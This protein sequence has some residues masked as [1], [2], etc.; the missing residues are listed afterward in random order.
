LVEDKRDIL[1]QVQFA[2]LLFIEIGL[3]EGGFFAALMA[4]TSTG[5]RE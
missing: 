1:S 4:L 2:D 3:G 5:A